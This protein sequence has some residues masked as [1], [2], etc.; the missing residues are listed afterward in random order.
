M[1]TMISMPK[2]NLLY[3]VYKP[4]RKDF[5]P[6]PPCENILFDWYYSE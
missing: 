1:L 3:I 6:C 5:W 4:Y 2:P